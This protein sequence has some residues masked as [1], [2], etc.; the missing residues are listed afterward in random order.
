MWMTR[1]IRAN[2]SGSSSAGHITSDVHPLVAG[3]E[4]V[5]TR[6][7]D[8]KERARAYYFE[9]VLSPYSC[10]ACGGPLRMTGRSECS[11][12]RGHTLDPTVAFQRSH[13][14]GAKLVRKTFHYACSGCQKTVPSR[15]LFNEKMFDKAYFREMMRESRARAEKKREE[16]RRLLAESRSGTLSLTEEPRLESIPGLVQAL[17]EFIQTESGEACTVSFDTEDCFRMDDYREH[18]LS[19]LG[20]S[21]I[22]FSD[23]PPL[24]ENDHQ[25]RVRRFITL[26]YMQHNPP[27]VELTQYASDLLVQRVYHATHVE[28]SAVFGAFEGTS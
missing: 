20:W 8:F 18:L 25:D 21:G 23:I 27:E 17:D 9:V 13:C 19:T 3:I 2:D 22:R 12:S 5:Q 7:S 26:V 4:R 10:P 16:I 1:N 6:L 14:C 28:G 11:C 15:F 24:I